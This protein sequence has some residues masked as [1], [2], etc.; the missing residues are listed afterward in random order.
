MHHGALQAGSAAPG[1]GESNDVYIAFRTC[2]GYAIPTALTSLFSLLLHRIGKLAH[3]T[4]RNV[5]DQI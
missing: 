3:N 5:G 2:S 1:V 4:S